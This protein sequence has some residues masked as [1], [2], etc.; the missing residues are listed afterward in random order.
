VT[1]NLGACRVIRLLAFVLLLA[2]WSSAAMAESDFLTKT[3]TPVDL[4]R[5]A[6]FQKARADAV[7]E[8]RE[9]GAAA[10]VKV[11]DAIL[12]GEEQ[13]VRGLDIRGNYR[14]RVAK[15]GGLGHLVI[16][17]WFNCRIDEDD[18]GYRLEKLT[19]SQ[20]LSGH[21]VDDSETGLIFYGA[22]HYSDEEPKAYNS[23][24]E[25]NN[26][27][28]FVKVGDKRFRLE[29]PLPFLE[30]TFDILELERR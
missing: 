18:V 7:K 13:P 15:L 3:L 20:R 21:F 9:Q 12:A 8:A 5:L 6:Q 1:P 17:D 30:S 11:L 4:G 28:R 23:D 29:L 19:G 16:Y 22:D 26:V 2:A 14:C 27:G 25:R 24:P 10:D